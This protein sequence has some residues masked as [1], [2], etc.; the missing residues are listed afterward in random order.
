MSKTILLNH[1]NWHFTKEN[2]GIPAAVMGETVALPHTWNA[3]DGQDGGNDYYRGTCWYTLALTKPAIPAG[4]KAVL[5][6]DGAAMTAVIYLNGEKLA[7]HKGGYSTFRV[8]LTDHLKEENLLAISVDNCDNDTVYPQKAD[9]TFYGGIYRDMTL[10]IVP[11]EHFALP[12]NGAPALKVTPIVTDLATKTVEVTVEAAVVGAQSVAFA[13]EGQSITAPVETA[14]QRLFSPCTMPI[15]GM[16]WTTPSFT[17]SLP[18]WAMARKL[19]PGSAA[20][21]LSLTPRRALS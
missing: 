7:E 10:H 8:D 2:P 5:Q 20:G 17:S 14:L 3:V 15:C 12:A 16:A 13:L 18:S 6:L 11:A 9:F 4:G 21:N 1:S 19:P